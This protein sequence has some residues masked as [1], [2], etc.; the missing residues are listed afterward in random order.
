M[1]CA[2]Y[3]H[4]DIDGTCKSL[5][6]GNCNIFTVRN[7]VAKVMFLHLSVCPQGGGS[8]VHAGMPLTPAPQ[9]QAPP[10]TRLPPWDLAPPAPAG[11]PPSPAPA[12]SP[13]YQLPP[14][15]PSRLRTVRILLECIFVSKYCHRSVFFFYV[16]TRE[17][18]FARPKI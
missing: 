8:S 6:F 12:G 16:G 5:N 17:S 10:S 14:P 11:T 18:I 7:E 13:R 3:K 9:H 1:K 2:A 4:D 15:L